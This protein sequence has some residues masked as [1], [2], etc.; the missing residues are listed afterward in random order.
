MKENQCLYVA[1]KC[2]HMSLTYPVFADN[3]IMSFTGYRIFVNF[4]EYEAQKFEQ[5]LNSFHRLV[6]IWLSLKNFALFVHWGVFLSKL[7]TKQCHITYRVYKKKLYPFKF[8]LPITY[9][10]NL[11]ALIALT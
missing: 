3:N 4:K 2:I 9:C 5:H 11:T 8:K 10:S 7:R 1:L 6:H